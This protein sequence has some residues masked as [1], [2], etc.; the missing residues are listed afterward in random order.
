MR[1]TRL[2]N[3]SVNTIFIVVG[4]MLSNRTLEVIHLAR[5]KPHAV[6]LQ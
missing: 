6:D 1:S 5:L 4:T 3:L 2:T